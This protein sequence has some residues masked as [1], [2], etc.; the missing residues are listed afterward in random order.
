M[1][2]HSCITGWI[3]VA[4][5]G[6]TQEEKEYILKTVLN[7]LPVVQG[8]EQNMY[9][10]IIQAG[11]YNS[12]SYF[13]EYMNKTN[14]LQMY[15][16]SCKFSSRKYG[17]LR[18][19]AF[20]YLFV[21]GDLRDVGFY[22][23]YSKFVKWITRLSKRVRVGVVD[24][25]IQGGYGSNCERICTDLFEDMFEEPSWSNPESRNWCEHLMWER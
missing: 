5:L 23:A 1:S 2:V 13:D 22:S 17:C 9:V 3:Y 15:D 18:S 24:V 11:G 21:E 25:V 14:N 16:T 4:P 7:H 10:H 20:Y 19:Q 8:S 6:R 12:S